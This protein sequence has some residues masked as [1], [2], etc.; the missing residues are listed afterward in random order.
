MQGSPQGK[1][2]IFGNFRDSTSEYSPLSSQLLSTFLQSVSL[3][4]GLDSIPTHST[5]KLHK[6]VYKTVNFPWSTLIWTIWRST[7]PLSKWLRPCGA[8]NSLKTDHQ[9]VCEMVEAS[10]STSFSSVWHA[11]GLV[12]IPPNSMK[13]VHKTAFKMVKALW[14]TLIWTIWLVSDSPKLP[15]NGPPNPPHSHLFGMHVGLFGY[16]QTP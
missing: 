10:W 6:T 14:S 4:C 8:P 3:E 12:R 5:N 16:S 11:C 1:Y 7:K 9:T 2:V 15:E 13:I